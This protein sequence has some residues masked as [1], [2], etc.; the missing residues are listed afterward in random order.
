MSIVDG[1]KTH[2]VLEV[3]EHTLQQL[4]DTKIENGKITFSFNLSIFNSK[5][6]RQGRHF[7][8]RYG[9]RSSE[10]LQ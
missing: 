7:I 10:C 5:K 4:K 2:Y 9:E 6:S 3:Q 1:S 8:G